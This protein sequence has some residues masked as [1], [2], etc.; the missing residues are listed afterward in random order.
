MKM[1]RVLQPKKG[2][3][4]IELLIVIAVIAILASIAIPNLLSS[5]QSANEASAA[6]T[7][8]YLV[9]AEA[10]YRQ[11]NRYFGTIA[12]LGAA[13]LIDTAVTQATSSANPKSGYMFNVVP[14]ATSPATAFYATATPVGMGGTQQFY[15]DETGSVFGADAG[16][17]TPTSDYSGVAPPSFTMLGT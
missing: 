12:D 5:R 7:M 4:L 10:E 11:H 17:T 15:T 16:A 14:S 2:F 1:R 13:N 6:K 8:K 3:T 9:A